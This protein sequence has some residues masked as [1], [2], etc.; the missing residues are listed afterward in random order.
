MASGCGSRGSGYSAAFA[1]SNE[2][3]IR[4]TKY[5]D[6]N[7]FFSILLGGNSAARAIAMIA[8]AA[9]FLLLGRAGGARA[10][11]RMTSSAIYGGPR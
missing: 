8:A 11:T 1:T 4:R 5:V 7:S 6:L 3:I 9:A 10:V 2:A